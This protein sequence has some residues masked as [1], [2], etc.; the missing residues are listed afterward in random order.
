MLN[1]PI[2]FIRQ[3]GLNEKRETLVGVKC[4]RYG[5]YSETITGLKSSELFDDMVW[6]P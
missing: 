2:V 5:M 4:R 6:L 1:E 3:C